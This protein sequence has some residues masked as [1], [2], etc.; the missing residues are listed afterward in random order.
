[1]D[2]DWGEVAGR[3]YAPDVGAPL[4]PSA[5]LIVAQF[6]KP[7]EQTTVEL[8]PA[9]GGLNYQALASFQYGSGF[10]VNVRSDYH[11][12]GRLYH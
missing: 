12:G 6:D 10:H 11:H 5:D 1:M 3:A 2:C 4:W 9:G 7:M 8:R